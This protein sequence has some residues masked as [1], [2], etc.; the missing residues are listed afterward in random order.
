MRLSKICF[1]ALTAAAL[2]ASVTTSASPASA[3]GLTGNRLTTIAPTRIVDTRGYEGTPGG[4]NW[5]RVDGF[6]FEFKAAGVAGIP[7]NAT[8]IAVT[9]TVV[10]AHDSGFLTAW[11]PSGADGAPNVSNVNFGAGNTIA[12]TSILPLGF[13]AVLKAGSG[14]VGITDDTADVLVDVTGYW[15]PVSGSVSAGRY[16]PVATATGRVADTRIKTGSWS[17]TDGAFIADAKL[18]GVPAGALAVA[19]NVTAVNAAPGFLTAYAADSVLPN[20]SMLNTDSA[21]QTR[22]AFAIVPLSPNGNIKVMPFMKTDIIVDI[23][24]YYTGSS[25]KASTDGLFTPLAP[26]RILDTRGSNLGHIEAGGTREANY[27][28]SGIAALAGNVTA[29]SASSSGFVTSYPSGSLRPNTSTVN[30]VAG[31]TVAN[32]AIVSA[33][34]RGVAFYSYGGTHLAFDVSGYFWGTPQTALAGDF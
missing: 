27:P 18:S 5:R 7:S 24:G 23:L 17:S 10:G 4:P 8:A 2:L 34:T 3:A 1:I 20:T 22:A 32:G 26:K 31:L 28:T 13:S 6:Q 21:G 33:S 15:T 12:N 16:V 30:V 9:F 29:I 25:A 14:R 11:A 19:V